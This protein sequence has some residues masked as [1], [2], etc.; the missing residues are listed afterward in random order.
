MVPDTWLPTCTVTTAC[1]VPVDETTWVILAVCT[2]VV[3]Y[4]GSLGLSLSCHQ[5]APPTPMTL[6][7]A[8]QAMAF[9]RF[10]I[11]LS[12]L[13]KLS[14]QNRWDHADSFGGKLIR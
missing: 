14:W 6:A 8:I 9:L 13:G 1:R 10:T 2:G 4:G 11:F 5:P 3:T 12:S 7:A